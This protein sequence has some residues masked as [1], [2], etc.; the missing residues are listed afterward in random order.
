LTRPRGAQHAKAPN[1]ITFEQRIIGQVPGNNAE[2][3]LAC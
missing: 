2:E 1:N 3:I